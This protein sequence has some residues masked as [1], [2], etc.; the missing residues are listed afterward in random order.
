MRAAF[1]QDDVSGAG[2]NGTAPRHF[3]ACSGKSE[4]RA[5]LIAEHRENPGCD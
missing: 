5:C 3:Q 1:E 2:L 4:E